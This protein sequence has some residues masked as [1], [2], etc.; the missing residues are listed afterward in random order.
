MWAHE[1]FL[2]V[3]GDGLG[4]RSK[5]GGCH[6]FAVFFLV[7]GACAHSVVGGEGVVSD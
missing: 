3:F 7:V 4:I 2:V 5:I 6:L 1:H